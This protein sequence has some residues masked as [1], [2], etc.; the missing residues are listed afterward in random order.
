MSRG[1]FG[2]PSYGT[3]SSGV[4]VNFDRPSS[5]YSE[6]KVGKGC[7]NDKHTQYTLGTVIPLLFL[8]SVY[9]R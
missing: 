5:R 4:R 3:L 1:E 8:C 7:N 9:F 2:S 6:G